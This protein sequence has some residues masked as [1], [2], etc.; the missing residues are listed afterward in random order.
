MN[1]FVFGSA[2]NAEASNARQCELWRGLGSFDKRV[3][4]QQKFRA[5]THRTPVKIDGLSA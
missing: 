3:P 4:L 2:Q 5:L 1:L